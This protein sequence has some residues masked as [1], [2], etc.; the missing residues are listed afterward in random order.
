M[1]HAQEILT[2]ALLM[3]IWG[4]PA[5]I[6]AVWMYQDARRRG[7]NGAAAWAI[8]GILAWPLTL[9]VYL[10]VHRTPTH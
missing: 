3:A 2:I 6:A 1:P 7:D 9:V 8:G 10:I 5:V 4:A